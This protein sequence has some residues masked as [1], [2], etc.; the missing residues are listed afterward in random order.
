MINWNDIDTVLLDMDGTLLDLHYDN[1]FWLEYLPVA[2]ARSRGLSDEHGRMELLGK[3]DAKRGQLDWYCL[4][5]WSEQLQLDIPA[6]K[7][8]IRHMIR[9]R[10]FALEFLKRLHAGPRT[11]L[12]VTN[13]HPVTL[14]IK[15]AQIDIR[16]WFDHVVVSHQYRAAKEQ[17]AFWEQLQ[18]QHP[19]N[20]ART[21]FIDDSESVLDTAREYGIAHLLTLL[22]PDSEQGKRLDTRFPGIH[23]FDEIMPTGNA[24]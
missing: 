14:D 12:L 13:A 8:E 7:R 17:L 16:P 1:H 4:D 6:L 11:T 19:F 5:H 2:Y 21:L 15:M 22:Q 10:P 3:L 20:P 18:S 23:H 24:T 9:I